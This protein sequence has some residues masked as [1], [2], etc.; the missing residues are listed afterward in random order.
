MQ[1]KPLVTTTWRWGYPRPTHNTTASNSMCTNKM[2]VKL[3]RASC[4][5]LEI[6]EIWMLRAVHI[7]DCEGWWLSG[8]RGSV[9]EHWRLK[10]EVSWVRLLAAADL[11]H[12]PLFSPH[13]IQ[14]LFIV[15]KILMTLNAINLQCVCV[16]MHWYAK[17]VAFQLL[18]VREVHLTS[19]L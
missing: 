9:A 7:E 2:L 4:L 15:S 16:H 3:L 6:N 13:N 17:P 18:K 5:K 8:C 1:L 11:F 14:I 19:W 10:P 12:F